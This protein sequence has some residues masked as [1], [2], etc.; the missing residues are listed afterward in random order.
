MLKMQKIM[1]KIIRAPPL[2]TIW[3][4]A[5]YIVIRKS[6]MTN[7][8]MA[9]VHFN[10]ALGI[11]SISGKLGNAIFYTRNGKQYVRRANKNNGSLQGIIG[12]LSVQHRSI[13]ESNPDLNT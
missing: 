10:P 2:P 12:P 3:K 8:T 7:H 13:I 6:P 1:Q 5:V 9:E 4:L 11:Q